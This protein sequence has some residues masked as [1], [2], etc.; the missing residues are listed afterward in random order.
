MS[1]VPG[2]GLAKGMALTLWRF[3]QPKV[4][5]LYPEVPADI[6]PKFRGRLQLLYDEWGTLKCETCFQCAQACPIECID[7]GGTDT[8]GR[9]A[10]HW[11]APETYG[12]RREESALRRSGRT[13]PD[14]AYE[15]FHEID[16]RAVDAILDEV[17]H[18]PREML[19]ILGAV[20]DAYGYVPVAAL[21][22]ISQTTGAWYAMLYGTATFYDHLAVGAPAPTGA[23]GSA[24][25]SVPASADA[26][27]LGALDGA[28]GGRGGRG[29]SA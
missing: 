23:A 18:D 29:A 9:F 3:F 6:P 17:D 15:H 27:F 26:A 24:G 21:K 12:E 11:G 2:L 13:V 19:R 20:Q 8:K 7:M 14:P 28:L 16:L 10:V 25:S 22:R 5:N 4:T 1:F